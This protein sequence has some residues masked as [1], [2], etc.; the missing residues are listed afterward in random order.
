MEKFRVLTM[1]SDKARRAAPIREVLV[2]ALGHCEERHC[3][4]RSKTK[5]S[6]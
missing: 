1:R 2:V 5:Q 4:A 3:E 6:R